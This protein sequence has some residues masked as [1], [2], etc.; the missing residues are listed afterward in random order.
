MVQRTVTKYECDVCGEDGER[1]TVT[2]P[3][4][5]MSLDRCEK[6]AKK[7]EAL[8]KEKGSFVHSNGHRATF[9]VSTVED[10]EAQRKRKTNSS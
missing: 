10:I 2:F 8:R 7:I 1:Y 6:H 4:G 5:F 9:K 3:D